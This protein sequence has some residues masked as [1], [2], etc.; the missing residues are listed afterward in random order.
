ME[1]AMASGKR[2]TVGQGAALVLGYAAI[3]VLAAV[4]LPITVVCLLV[5]ALAGRGR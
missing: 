4:I 1:C 2:L 3:I 5:E